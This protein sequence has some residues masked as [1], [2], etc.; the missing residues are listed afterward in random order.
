MG[1]VIDLTGKRFGRL[2]VLRQATEK[3]NNRIC[4]VCICDCGK[5]VIISGQSLRSG[6]TK[7]CGCLLRET[8]RKNLEPSIRT[9]SQ[10]K[11]RLYRVWCAMKRRCYNPNTDAYKHYG[12]RGIKVCDEWKNDFVS[13][14]E[15]ALANGYDEEAKVGQ[16]TIDRKDNNKDYSPENCHWVTQKEQTRN[17]RTNHYVEYQGETVTIAELSEIT[18]IPYNKLQPRIKTLGWSAEK[19]VNTPFQTKRV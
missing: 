1:E 7:S 10:S 12:G 8:A 15:W 5:K 17:T 18:G 4:W 2:T 13:F 11:T 16:C 6:A 14:Q 19:A 9:H 3:Q